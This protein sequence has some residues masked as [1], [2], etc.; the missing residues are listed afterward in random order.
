V[1]SCR[2]QNQ[3]ISRRWLA[4]PKVG[5][6]IRRGTHFDTD[7][8]VRVH[9]ARGCMRELCVTEGRRPYEL[10]GEPAHAPATIRRAGRDR[11]RGRLCVAYSC[12]EPE[13]RE[14]RAIVVRNEDVRAAQV[15]V[16]NLLR[17]QV[18]EALCN[19]A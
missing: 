13:I 15:A 19:F 16:D 11:D 2:P 17:V 3:S 18:L 6:G 1:Y 4:A 14:T 9:V 7:A 12:G 8:G 10:R 5:I